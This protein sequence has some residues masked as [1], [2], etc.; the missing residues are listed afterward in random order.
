MEIKNFLLVVSLLGIAQGLLV[1]AMILLRAGKRPNREWL[2]SGLFIASIIVMTLVTTVNSGLVIERQWMRMIEVFITL[3]IGPMFYWY[4][5]FQVSEKPVSSFQM[6]VHFLPAMVWLGIEIVAQWAQQSLL[7][8]PFYLFIAHFQLYVFFTASYYFSGAYRQLKPPAQNW[9]G[10]LLC[11][12][13]FL[14]IGQWLRFAFVQWESLFLIVPSTAACSFY[15]ITFIGLQRSSLW[16]KPAKHRKKVHT[17]DL[18]SR[19]LQRQALEALMQEEERYRDP[20]LNRNKLAL[21]LDIT[22]NQLTLLIQESYGLSFTD[23]INRWRLQKVQ[24]LLL[25][26]AWH[27]LTL[28][29]IGHAAG[30]Q[31]RS[32]FYRIFRAGTGKTPANYRKEKS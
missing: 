11:F 27:H 10:L 5:R 17:F 3:L 7:R 4:T 20:L 16:P 18:Q 23:Y 15:L 8:L 13:A 12:F 29:A 30:F 19:A 1:T 24:V 21:A 2:L 14:C 31:S 6:S 28:E 25:D 22:P 26:P 32:A 9:V